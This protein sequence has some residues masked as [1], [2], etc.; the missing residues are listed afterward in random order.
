[1]MEMGPL[2]DGDQEAMQHYL[3]PRLDDN[4]R[5]NPDEV[6]GDPGGVGRNLAA[7]APSL[8]L[9]ELTM[10]DFQGV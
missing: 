10:R 9:C 3:I 4:P 2:A 5:P 6:V 7:A 8:S 1:M